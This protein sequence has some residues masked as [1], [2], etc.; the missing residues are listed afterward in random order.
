MSVH[1]EVILDKTAERERERESVCVCVCV[2]ACVCVCV[3]ERERE[4]RYL[5][6]DGHHRLIMREAARKEARTLDVA[7][8]C[9]K[10]RLLASLFQP[11]P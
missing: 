10:V 9:S 6:C 2:R 1:I 8:A 3:C 4:F 5:T 11:L 7:D